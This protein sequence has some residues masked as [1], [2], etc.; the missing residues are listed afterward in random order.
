MDGLENT[1]AVELGN[2]GSHSNRFHSTYTDN[3]ILESSQRA[4]GK[5]VEKAEKIRYF[6]VALF[7]ELA[8]LAQRALFAAF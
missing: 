4:G 8:Y 2:S 7:S 1:R 5:R 3:N 6:F